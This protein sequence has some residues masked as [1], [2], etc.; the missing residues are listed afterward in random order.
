MLVRIRRDAS[1]QMV[2]AHVTSRLSTLVSALTVQILKD[3]WTRPSL[4]TGVLPPG[5]ATS[6]EYGVPPGPPKPGEEADPLTSTPSKPS[7]PPPEFSF[8]TPGRNAPALVLPGAHQHR[9]HS[10]GLAY[11]AGPYGSML[12]L[13]LSRPGVPPHGAPAAPAF[14]TAFGSVPQRYGAQPGGGPFGLYRP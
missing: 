8:H 7:S 12:G 14:R 4:A 11:A 13:G 10:L 1:E 6:V 3:D 2:L 5:V 9:P